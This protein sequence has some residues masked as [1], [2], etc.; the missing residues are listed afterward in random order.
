MTITIEQGITIGDGIQIGPLPIVK[1]GVA[2][3]ISAVGNAQVSTSQVK[4]GTGSYTSN[5]LSGYLSVTPT[6][7]M[8]WGT[9]NFTMEFWYRPVAFAPASTL[10]GMRPPGGQGAYPT[11]F[12][13]TNSSIGYY[14]L[15]NTRITSA[16]NVIT[17]NAWNSIAVVRSSGSTK[18][19]INGNQSGATYTDTNNYAA[20]SCIIGG[21]DFSLGASPILG[22]M[23][24][25]R[26]SNIARYTANYT[27]A[28]QAFENDQNTVLLIHC[29]GTNGSKV[30]TD[31]SSTT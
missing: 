31:S 23:D 15:T 27:P 21:N 25:I 11:I 8:A 30:F 18:M 19:Y 12:I 22:N 20:G 10:V 6:T 1:P 28:T 17:A 5:S 14:T 26:F 3:T 2:R 16:T 24:E 13:D 4:F 29:D 9:G 7:G